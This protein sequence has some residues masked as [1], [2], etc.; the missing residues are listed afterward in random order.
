VL[1]MSVLLFRS[2]ASR[3]L[4]CAAVAVAAPLGATAAS[5]GDGA[6]HLDGSDAVALASASGPDARV[7]PSSGRKPTHAGR[8]SVV[9]GLAPAVASLHAP[10]P[11]A[12][13]A[14]FAPP[15]L[16]KRP[17]SLRKSSRGPPPFDVS[18][19]TS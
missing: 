14:A 1:S 9:L 5:P 4:I 16:P 13:V 17:L 15:S 11:V 19:F 12:F 3:L 2:L 10:A 18:L 6:A 7:A 8:L